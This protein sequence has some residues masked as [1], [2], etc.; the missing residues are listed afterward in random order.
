MITKDA[1]CLLNKV[2]S[3]VKGLVDEIVIVDNFSKDQTIKI[4][5]KFKARIFYRHSKNLGDQKRYGVKKTR[6]QWI[7]ILDSD[8][9]IS[10]GLFKEIL[11][12]KKRGWL[13]QKDGYLISYQNHFLGKKIN[14]GG[15]NYQ[16]L[17]LFKKGKAFIKSALIHENFQLTNDDKK[18]YLKNKI[19]HY[20]Y[21]SLRQM[22]LK[23]T[24][25]AIREACQKAKNGEKSSLTKVILYPLHMFYARFIKD[26]GYR[27]GLWRI[28]LDFGF[29][30]MEF[31]TYFL[32]FFPKLL[33]KNNYYA[34]N[35]DK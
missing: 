25:Y 27:D 17:R 13:D 26:Q 28:P 10:R 30:Y 3:S 4:A 24:D 19:F 6:Y 31:L 22:F 16:M 18:G 12:L 5:Q 32:L 33:K 20:S 29:A 7:L 8:E 9:V 34:K 35:I 15:E 21:R 14:Y 2:L 1:G 11:F 23:F